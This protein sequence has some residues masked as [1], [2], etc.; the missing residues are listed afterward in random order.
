MGTGCF[1]A[2]FRR[3]RTSPS[4]TYPFDPALVDDLVAKR[5]ALHCFDRLDAARTA[6][7]VVDMQNGFV[8][9]TNATSLRGARDIVPT[10][11]RIAEAVR[12]RGGEVVWIVWALTP[13]HAHRWD[14]FFDD[15]LGKAA[16][17]RFRGAFTLGRESQKLWPGLDYREGERIIGKTNFSG[18]SG[19]QGALEHHL[20]AHGRD[21]LLIAG[22]VTN[23][24]CESTARD[25]AFANF[26]T[27]MVADANAGR[28]DVDNR[29]TFSTFIR[30]FG[31]V[32]TS[33]EI[34]ARLGAQNASS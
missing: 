32:M 34:I 29:V 12:K 13:D 4:V 24:C 23:V 2:L 8:D 16:S 25:A 17:E 6:L 19:S 28:S 20:R 30:A 3:A 9:E 7:L 33:D 31:D 18:F 5:G 22:T 11:N 21:T 10:I 26:R 15:V 1:A 27:I 14:V